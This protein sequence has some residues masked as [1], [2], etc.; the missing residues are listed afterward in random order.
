MAGEMC[1]AA[2]CATVVAGNIG[3][4]VLDAAAGRAATAASAD[5]DVWVL[6]L[7]SFQLETHA[8]PR[9][10]D[11][12]AVLNVTEDHLDR[13]DGMADYA[14]AKARIFHGRGVQVLNRDDA[15][16]RSMALAGRAVLLPSGSTSRT[17]EREW[18]LRTQAATTWLARQPEADARR[19]VA[20]CRAC[21]TPPMRSPRWRSRAPSAC[22]MQPLAAG[23]APSSRACRTA[24]RSS[25]RSSGVRFYD[26]SKGTNVGATVAALERLA[27]SRWC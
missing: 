15:A 18:G 4:P 10:L 27:R 11:A 8:S 16:S 3:L 17:G 23:A 7:S 1:R 9:A 20:R 19:R 25:P 5:T 26:D 2:A 21:T 14:A 22:R 13:Y 24:C 12:A 6:E